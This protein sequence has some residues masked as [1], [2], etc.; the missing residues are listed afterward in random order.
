MKID[1]DRKSEIIK[2]KLLGKISDD[3][4]LSYFAD[5]RLA[6]DKFPEQIL[7]SA[8]RERNVDDVELGI[9]IYWSLE[10][11]RRPNIEAKIWCDLLA[12]DWHYS[13]ED[14]AFILQKNPDAYAVDCLYETA[15]RKFEYRDYDEAFQLARKCIKGLA[16]IG[17]SNA[18]ENLEI[19]S[20]NENEVLR[21]Y[22]AK[23]LSR[24]V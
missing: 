8:L 11:E 3:E 15:T 7:I 22:A 2:A 1:E 13:H 14:I 20:R 19:L 18:L 10:N 16:A 5:A 23:E 4:F 24:L 6:D 17:N 21:S 9:I 12:Q